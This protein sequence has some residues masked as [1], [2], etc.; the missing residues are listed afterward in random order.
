MGLIE[1]L[2]SY[3]EGINLSS[4]KKELLDSF[5]T[6]GFPSIKD[7]EWKYTS[8]RKVVKND[9]KIDESSF[10]ISE[11]EIE[12]YSLNLVDRILFVNG[13]LISKP[14]IK[15]VTISNFSEGNITNNT[16]MSSLNSALAK[17]GF[18]ISV[19]K[20]IVVENPIEILF[21]TNSE[22]DNFQQ[23]RNQISVGENAEIKFVER[24]QNLNKSKCFVNHF[25]QINV[26]K[27]AKIEY[28]KIQNNTN[29]STLIDTL[30]VFQESDTNCC[31][32]TLIFGGELTRNNLNF[33][34][35]GTNCDSNMNGVSVLDDNQLADNHTFVDH[36]QAHC[37][38][39]EMYK[40]IYLGDSKG[41]FNGKIMVRQDAQKIDA[42]QSNN[43]LLLSETSTIDSKPQLEIYADDVKCSHGC[44]IGQLDEDALFY[45]RSRGIGV[46]EAKAVL[47]YAFAS[48]AIENISV[49]EVKLLAQKLL[50]KKLN[51]DLDFSL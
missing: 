12:N 51:V 9:F 18:T 4:D 20:N 25:T 3:T 19:D 31:V 47:T 28:N 46:E 23:Y 8:L 29:N 50:A 36:K 21:F 17:K 15:G 2:K 1:N 13:N 24:I 16:E 42:F 22:T 39:N 6:K 37:R 44:T 26:A 10:D 45:M 43:N 48:E 30:N 34:Q 40:G 27:N 33:E 41:V 49:E 5:L 32:N 7:E 38:S 14:S 11:N 35:N